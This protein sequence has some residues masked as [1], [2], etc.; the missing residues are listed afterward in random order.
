MKRFGYW[1]LT[2]FFLI[3]IFLIF[4]LAIFGYE[5][6]RFNKKIQDLVN[7]NDKNINLNFDKVKIS[8]DIKKITLFI[9]LNKPLLK[10]SEVV[11]PIKSLRADLNLIALIQNKNSIKRVILNT[12][13]I[14]FK[15]IRPIIVKSKPGN[16]KTI[17]LNNVSKSK[18]KIIS[19]IY[20]DKD[21]NLTK[22]TFFSGEVKDTNLEFDKK[23]FLSNL[24]FNFIYKNNSINFAN[25]SGK[26]NEL[27][28]Y[29]SE[30]DYYLNNNY[31]IAGKIKSKIN[32]SDKIILKLFSKTGIN[33][34]NFSSLFINGSAS[35]FFNLKLDKTLDI[36]EFKFESKASLDDVKISFKK[37]IKSKLFKKNFKDLY[38]KN[39]NVQINN[40][41]KQINATIDTS[42]VL[43]NEIL[44]LDLVKKNKT[45]MFKV[46]FNSSDILNIPL[47]KFDIDQNSY[48]SG[49]FYFDKK[50]NLFS[51]ILKYEDDQN[52]FEIN[53][54]FLDKNFNLINFDKITVKTKLKNKFNNNFIVNNYKNKKIKIT[55]DIFDAELL[56]EEFSKTDKNNFLKNLSGDIEIDFAEVLTNTDFPLKKFRMIG[57]IKKGKFEEML[58]KSEFYEN[59]YLDISLK[60]EKNSNFKVLEIFSDIPRPLI[61][62]YKFF[63]G[64]EQGSLIYE[65]RFSDS[66]LE[67]E[68]KIDNFKLT[69]AP[70]FAKILT[71]ADLEGLK[72][73]LKGEGITFDTMVI[74][75][76]SDKNTM[77]IEE[78]FMIGS[79]ISILIDGYIDRKSGLISISGTLVP[80]KTLN[81]LVSKIPL[82]GDILIGKKTGEGLFGVSFKIKGMQNNLKTSVNPVKTLTPRF[83]T[84]ALESMKEKAAK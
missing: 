69:K 38:L 72:D 56:S 39:F 3:I 27:E 32:S 70:V 59:K 48:L 10:Y 37:Q 58:G 47:I 20:V 74:K 51:E 34:N 64:I 68:L 23:Y 79:S 17:L 16:F 50:N 26:L 55:G 63:D 15:K 81:T 78:I 29:D 75:Y 1:L 44:K 9:K 80:A 41:E 12:D 13:F 60:K 33:I 31:E 28:L 11:I 25:I 46:S 40:F 53:K 84:R 52:L 43:E 21:L 57:K 35:T 6:D 77:N 49:T 19:E 76:N 42:I 82:L 22:E 61:N 73:A 67:A 5:T 66:F 30:I 24:K 2:S 83:I 54:L 71:L 65:S 18:V 8:L 14:D 4:Y 7:K 45:N 36:D 62:N